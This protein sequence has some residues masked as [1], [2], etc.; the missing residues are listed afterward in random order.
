MKKQFYTL[1]QKVSQKASVLQ[2]RTAIFFESPFGSFLKTWSNRL[3]VLGVLVWLI[4]QLTEIGWNQVLLSLPTNPWFYFLFVLIYFSLPLAEMLIYRISWTYS[5]RE[6]FKPFMLKKIYNKDVVGY[7]GEFYI[8]AWAKQHLK[9]SRRAIFSTIKDN[10]ILSTIA[11]TV[12]TFGLLA[13]LLFTEQIK[14]IELIPRSERVY[15]LGGVA[16]SLV[17]IFFLVYFRKHIMGMSARTSGLIFGIHSF[18]LLFGQ[19]LHIIQWA[20]IMPEVA[21]YVWFTFVSIQLILTR[22]PFLPN[23]DLI[24][25]GIS[26]ELSG[27]MDVSVAGV[28]GLM[29]ANTVLTKLL[30]V[31][32]FVIAAPSKEALISE[33]NSTPPQNSAPESSAT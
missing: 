15:A 16:F 4:F 19:L 22:I 25:L 13:V 9:L 7:S 21:L 23:Q 10:N 32:F 12:V 31:F 17:M 14:V 11:S 24:F 1:T 5:L 6:A 18:R 26:V 33:Y 2:Q 30:N 29:L 27:L 28:A 20:I 3:L 8:Y